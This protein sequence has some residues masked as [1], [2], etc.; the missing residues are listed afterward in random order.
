MCIVMR[1]FGIRILV[2]G[3]FLLGI[4]LFGV[5]LLGILLRLSLAFT[6]LWVF[7]RVKYVVVLLYTLS[8]CFMFRYYCSS[9]VLI[10]EFLKIF[11]RKK[12]VKKIPPQDEMKIGF[13]CVV[14]CSLKK[15]LFLYPGSV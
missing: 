1:C 12:T 10:C 4:L 2:F 8:Y 5:F 15:A 14:S 7:C 13:A 6:A 9:S 3:V 11:F